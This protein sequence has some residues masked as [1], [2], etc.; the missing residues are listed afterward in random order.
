MTRASPLDDPAHWRQRAAESRRI[1]EQLD[2]PNQKKT[3]LEIA[4]SYEQLA[5]RLE[6]K[7]SQP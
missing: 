7:K 6:Q 4:E 5:N 2:D 3:M 1:A